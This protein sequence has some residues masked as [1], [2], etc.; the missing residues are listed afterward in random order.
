MDVEIAAQRQLRLLLRSDSACI[1][2]VGVYSPAPLTFDAPSLELLGTG[3]TDL[4][5]PV[6]DLLLDPRKPL[7]TLALVDALS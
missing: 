2:V 1:G 5:P 7:G 6:R 4:E 3:L